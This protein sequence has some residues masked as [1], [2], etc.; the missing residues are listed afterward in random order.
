M[1]AFLPNSF[2]GFQV[3]EVVFKVNSFRIHSMNDIKGL[4]SVD[5]ERY[6]LKHILKAQRS[7]Y[8]LRQIVF[9]ISELNT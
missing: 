3:R 9:M 6:T 5:K 2:T 1:T 7:S 4:K 8:R